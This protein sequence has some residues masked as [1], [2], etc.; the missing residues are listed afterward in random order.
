LSDFTCAECGETLTDG[1]YI[2][3]SDEGSDMIC[4]GCHKQLAEWTEVANA[5]IRKALGPKEQP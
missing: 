3:V 2:I 5:A 4:G 1:A